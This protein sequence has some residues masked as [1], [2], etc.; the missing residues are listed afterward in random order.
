M[1]FDAVLTHHLQKQ[2]S[3]LPKQMPSTERCRDQQDRDRTDQPSTP[4]AT[5]K[6]VMFDATRG[7]GFIKPADGGVDVFVHISAAE[8]ADIAELKVGDQIAFDLGK[9][10]K[11]RE[12]ATNL[13]R[14]A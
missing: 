12:I 4:T 3:Q 1:A 11:G 5:G 13:R 2:F 14:V 9:R 8:R 6:V 7:F 10:H